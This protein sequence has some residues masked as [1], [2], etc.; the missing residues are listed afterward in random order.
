MSYL[1]I[2]NR[3]VQR[4]ASTFSARSPLRRVCVGGGALASRLVLLL[5]LVPSPPTFPAHHS[6]RPL[7]ASI[8]YLSGLAETIEAINTCREAGVKLMTALQRRFDPNFARVKRA[9]LEGE[10]GGCGGGKARE[11][12]RL[13]SRQD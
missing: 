6:F 13:G 8:A 9:I 2:E 10:V 5:C 11:N 4:P 3:P 1:S 7:T 12:V